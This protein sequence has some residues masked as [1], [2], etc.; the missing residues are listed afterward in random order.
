MFVLAGVVIA[1][2]L[3]LPSAKPLGIDSA[4]ADACESESRS[5][6]SGDIHAEQDDTDAAVAARYVLP[7]QHSHP[8]AFCYKNI[9]NT[10]E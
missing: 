2:L 6:S 10:C 5:G 9:F 8:H 7:D 1:S 3:P 4:E